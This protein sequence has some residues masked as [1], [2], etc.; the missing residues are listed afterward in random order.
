MVEKVLSPIHATVDPTYQTALQ[1]FDRAVSYLD[2]PE[3]LIE[4]MK[5]PRRDFT[6]NFPVR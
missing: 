2:L 1:Q 5:W 6:V 4:F 3:G